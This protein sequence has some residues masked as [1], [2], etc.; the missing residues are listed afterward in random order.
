MSDRAGSAD[1]AQAHRGVTA[2]MRNVLRNRPDSEHEMTINRIVISTVVL[3]WLLIAQSRG[4]DAAQG[5]FHEALVLF[6]IYY[7]CS[8]GLFAH[9][10]HDP[11]VSHARRTVA[12]IIDIG[13]LSYGMHVG[14][15]AFAIGYPLYLWI[16]I[17]NGFRFGIRYL[18]GAALAAIAGFLYLIMKTPLWHNNLELSF[19]LMAG[20]VLLP[21]YC[22]VL[23]RKLSEA[24]QQ[25][26]QANKAKS[27]F[28]AGV[29]HELRTPLNAII[30]L[31][32]L[33][34]QAPIPREQREMSETIGMSGRSLLK[35]IN[36][37]LD[38]SRLEAHDGQSGIGHF[39]LFQS[40]QDVRRVLASLAEAKGLFLSV[41]IS[42]DVVSRVVG[43]RQH[44]EEIITNLVGNATKF[45]AQG[46]IHLH[47]SNSESELPGQMLHFSVRDTGIGIS[48]SAQLRI[49][50]QFTQADETIVDRFGGTGL[51]L[52][53]AKRLVETHGGQIGVRSVVGEGSEFWFTLPFAGQP[54][55]ELPQATRP[56]VVLLSHDFGL[57]TRLALECA[58]LVRLTDPKR[59]LA[60]ARAMLDKGAGCLVLIDADSMPSDT[61]TELV[62][63]DTARITVGSCVIGIMS[64]TEKNDIDM[65]GAPFA[66]RLGLPV[67]PAAFRQLADCVSMRNVQA[68]SS[69]SQIVPLRI[70]VAED[71]VTNQIV[72]RKLLERD[73][74]VVRIVSNG[75][76]AVEVLLKQEFDIVL[77]DI[78]MPVM[79]GLEATKLYRFAALGSAHVP[80]YALTADVTEE[81]RRRCELSGMDGCLHK[82]IDQPELQE[83]FR[84]CASGH[85]PG[86]RS[87]VP[88]A[89]Q[90]PATTAIT[91]LDLDA[92]DVID[93]EGLANLMQLGD[94]AFMRELIGQFLIGST[95]T[96]QSITDAVARE[97]VAAFQD[98][99]HAL[100][101]SA[102]NIGAKRIFALA[103]DW[104]ATTHEELARLGEARVRM[105]TV[106]LAEAEAALRGWLHDQEILVRK[107]G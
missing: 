24:K 54:A 57:H 68:P 31:A 107:A 5:V 88:E 55:D 77:M 13:M 19:G 2:R 73:R 91:P 22:S 51:G 48:P 26:E 33:M 84:R 60:A 16:I 63:A 70:L 93:L 94:I 100:R 8:I 90:P 104:R 34:R 81:T 64:R 41:S 38:L 21:A 40:L 86:A 17:G 106:T 58:D 35:L 101:S 45:T 92:I 23:I 25:A 10:L 71:N 9:I 32:D 49:F 59:A 43:N 20:L 76:E 27:L 102:A 80:I 89:V 53:L 99:L 65:A 103:L 52:A 98:V 87:H 37:I 36:S 7:V 28:L 75:E 85:P 12:I 67:D 79:N 18:I 96:L 69:S 56:D 72:I 62:Q 39:D 30:T 50:D 47:V 44:V 46:G 14:E 105:L 95:E 15:S 74:H 3:G 97:D 4:H 78:N 11:R 61:L 1:A 82:P 29:S 83:I 66:V 6:G 42:G